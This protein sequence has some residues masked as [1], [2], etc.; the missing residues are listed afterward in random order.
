MSI[1]PEHHWF[2]ERWCAEMAVEYLVSIPDTARRLG[3]TVEYVHQSIRK[4]YGCGSVAARKQSV[5]WI[6][7]LR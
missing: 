2:F 4:V 7:P 3:T 6:G 5:G 1:R